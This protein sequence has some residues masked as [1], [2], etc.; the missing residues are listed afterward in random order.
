MSDKNGRKSG[1]PDKLAAGAELVLPIA[2]LIFTIYYFTTIINVPWTAQVSAFFVGTIL[3]GLIIA[4]ITRTIIKVRRGEATLSM[5]PLFAPGAY[6]PKRLALFGLT[7]AYVFLL[8]WGGFTIT[9]FFFLL[10]A[11]LL[12]S[13]GK[14]KGLIFVLSLML[15]VGGYFLFIVAF[16]TRFP[17]GPV[18]TL[19]HGVF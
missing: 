1:K 4:L 6:V 11:M 15:S 18:E 16:N 13:E 14:K 10:I 3:I 9:T 17:R 2:A 5:T 7:L 19:L 12:L 8:E